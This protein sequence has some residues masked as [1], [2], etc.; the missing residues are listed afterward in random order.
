MSLNN[1][2]RAQRAEDAVCAYTE[3]KGEKFE[4]NTDEVHDLI[5]DLMHLLARYADEDGNDAVDYIDKAQRLARLHF[6]AEHN[7]PEEA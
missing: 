5:A 7:N 1:K 3:A 2:E 6:D 4:G